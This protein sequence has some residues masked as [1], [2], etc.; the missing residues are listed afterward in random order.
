MFPLQNTAT[1]KFLKKN[2]NFF[3]FFFKNI[4]YFGE[5]HSAGKTESGH[6]SVKNAE[7]FAEN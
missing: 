3:R 7:N 2:F 6:L 4:F 1:P 5:S